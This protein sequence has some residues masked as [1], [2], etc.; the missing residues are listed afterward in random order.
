[1]GLDLVKS[2]ELAET[3]AYDRMRITLRPRK[4]DT[5]KPYLERYGEPF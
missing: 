2:A 5:K 3:A 4:R 1:M